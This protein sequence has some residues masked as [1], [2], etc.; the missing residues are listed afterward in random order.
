[1]FNRRVA[2]ISFGALLYS[3]LALAVI[4]STPMIVR[5]GERLPTPLLLILASAAGPATLFAGGRDAWP[6]VAVV[7]A[8]ITLCLGLAR[9]AWRR[10]PETEWFV[11]WLLGAALFWAGSPWLLIVARI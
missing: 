11:F 8:L 6:V 7:V 9:L 4:A 3:A 2:W 5:V 10:A 1:M